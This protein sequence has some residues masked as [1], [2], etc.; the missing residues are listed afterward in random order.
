MQTAFRVLAR[1]EGTFGRGEQA[2]IALVWPREF[3]Y[4]PPGKFG[5]FQHICG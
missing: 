1:P 2:E 5:H 3:R 4:S